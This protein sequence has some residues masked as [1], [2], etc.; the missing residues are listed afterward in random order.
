MQPSALNRDIVRKQRDERIT[1]GEIDNP[2]DRSLEL[3]R[4]LCRT[5]QFTDGARTH[6]LHI[7]S[8]HRVGPCQRR[9]FCRL[10]KPLVIARARNQ[11]EPRISGP[12]DEETYDLVEVFTPVS[13]INYQSK[14]IRAC[15]LARQ[16]VCVKTN[17]LFEEQH[18]VGANPV[19]CFNHQAR[20]ADSTR[21][22]DVDDRVSTHELD[23][24]VELVS[25]ADQSLGSSKYRPAGGVFQSG[26]RY[27]RL[28]RR[29]PQQL[30]SGRE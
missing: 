7:Q 27:R 8:P 14:A 19:G 10:P 2:L 13:I 1:A 16:P 11:N 4:G 23:N 5:D 6:P 3:K 20:L 22:D 12:S 21:P 30:L 15:E 9:S 24:L 29:Q 28:W 17:P 18:P 25:T 26:Q